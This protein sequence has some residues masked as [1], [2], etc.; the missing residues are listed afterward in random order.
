MATEQDTYCYYSD[1]PSPAA[2]M[3]AAMP[4]TDAGT[5]ALTDKDID[6]IIEMAWEDRTPFDAIRYQFGLTES[7]VRK[8]MK[9]ELKF[10]SYKL[11]RARVEACKTKHQKSRSAEINRFK[12]DRQRAISQNRISKRR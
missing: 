9:A 3:D 7:E 8:I 11:W 5:D 6:R 1:L 12:C 2:Y 10:R 4:T